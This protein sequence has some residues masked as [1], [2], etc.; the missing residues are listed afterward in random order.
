MQIFTDI[1]PKSTTT[2]L[3]ATVLDNDIRRVRFNLRLPNGNTVGFEQGD[4]VSANGDASTFELEVDTSTSGKYG[5]R[6][7]I[8]DFT[9]NNFNYPLD[10]SQIEFV[11]ADTAAEVVAGARTEIRRIIND[12]FDPDPDI[13]VNLAAKFVRHGF[14]D[15]VGGCD[16]CVDMTNP[17]N[18]GLD[19]PIAALEPVVNMFSHFGVTRADIWVLAALEGAGGQQPDDDADARDFD[20]EWIGR[21]VCDG[22]DSSQCKNGLCTQ[23]RGPI[24]I[25]PSPDVD[26][27]ALLEYFSRE[28]D[29]DERDTV[30]IMGAHTLGTLARE[31]SG[32]NGPNGWLGNTRQFGNGYYN[33][34]IGGQNASSPVEELVAA[35]NWQQVLVN[36]SDL[37]GIPNRFEW[38]RGSDPHFVMVNADIA[39]VRDLS[40]H[41]SADEATAGQVD[42]QFR[43]N[44]RNCNPVACPQA[45]LTF[46]IAAEYKFDN[47]AFLEDFE[48]AFKR[49]LSKGIDVSAG[50]L[51]YPCTAPVTSRRNLRGKE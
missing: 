2:K 51:S 7:N 31:N 15:C 30:A 36:N 35:S 47:A 33:D 23:D 27:H 44:R 19:V 41:I 3:I 28:F 34:L 42:C 10:G 21:P 17:D 16:G 46:N 26:T 11:V 4:L 40:G 6:L 38:E 45:A 39:L 32:Y 50:C 9:G 37:D 8:Q 49:M 5:Y 12:A 14:H 22:L 24:R 29:F 20:M 18:A 1:L 48:N 43:C 25:L 13:S